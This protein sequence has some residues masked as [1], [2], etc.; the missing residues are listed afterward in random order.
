M[1]AVGLGPLAGVLAIAAADICVLAKLFAEAIENAD[2]RQTDAMTAVGGTR[3]L[4]IRFGLLPQVLPGAAGAGARTHSRATRAAQRS[5]AW[6]GPAASDCRSPNG[7]R[8]DTGMR[9]RSSSS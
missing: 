9:C 3:L 7:S 6:W 5:W 1:R 4:E 2:P 8:C